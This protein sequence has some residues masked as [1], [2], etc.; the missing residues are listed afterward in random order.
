MIR[1]AVLAAVG[2]NTPNNTVYG[3]RTEDLNMDGKV[4]Y[5]N[6]SNDRMVIAENVGVST[7]NAILNQHTP[8]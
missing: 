3:Y 6:T 8:N 4:R 2:T 1:L 7:P 5:N